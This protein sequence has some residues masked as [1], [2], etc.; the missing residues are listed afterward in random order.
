MGQG[1]YLVARDSVDKSWPHRAYFYLEIRQNKLVNVFL[2]DSDIC[3]KEKKDSIERGMLRGGVFF[4]G[5]REGTC[6]WVLSKKPE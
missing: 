4:C 3:Y 1:Y 5:G 6:C 2:S